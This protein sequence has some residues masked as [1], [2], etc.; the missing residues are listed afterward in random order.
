VDDPQERWRRGHRLRIRCRKQ[1]YGTALRVLLPLV[2]AGSA[3]AAQPRA[4]SCDEARWW[5]GR[6]AVAFHRRSSAS[7]SGAQASVTET[8]VTVRVGEVREQALGVSVIEDPE[9]LGISSGPC[10]QLGVSS[11][12]H[13]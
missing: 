7:P 6:A 9:R 2:Q 4:C 13:P 11:L 5:F 10:E 8:G 1:A 12:H 3:N